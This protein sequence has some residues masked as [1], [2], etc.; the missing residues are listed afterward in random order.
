L[1][2]HNRV[3]VFCTL[4][5][6]KDDFFYIIILPL[7]AVS[8]LLLIIIHDW[9]PGLY[10]E[11]VRPLVMMMGRPGRAVCVQNLKKTKRPDSSACFSMSFDKERSSVIK[12]IKL[13]SDYNEHNNIL[14]E[15][16]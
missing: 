1:K 5:P 13:D 12:L 10:G 7:V 6:M 14:K 16:A 11:Y 15:S 4:F 3:L 9:F 2:T 8:A